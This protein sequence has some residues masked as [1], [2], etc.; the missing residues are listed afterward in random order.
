MYMA[1]LQIISMFPFQPM[2]IVYE[3]EDDGV[4]RQSNA[5]VFLDFGREL[6]YDK[7]G[8]LMEN[9]LSQAIL[10]IVRE[11]KARPVRHFVQEEEVTAIINKQREIQNARENKF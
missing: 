6:V 7:N 4:S 11:Q 2:E 9:N 3:R 5:I 8:S 10:N 1:D